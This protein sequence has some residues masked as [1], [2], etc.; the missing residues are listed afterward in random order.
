VQTP[1]DQSQRG[2]VYLYSGSEETNLLGSL[3]PVSLVKKERSKS[4]GYKYLFFNPVFS[5]YIRRKG[6]LKENDTSMTTS[7]LGREGEGGK[8]NLLIVQSS[9]TQ[10][11]ATGKS[12]RGGRWIV[13]RLRRRRG[14]E[15][16][17]R[18]LG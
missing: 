12:L 17:Y 8:S 11:P 6:K 5:K 13:L 10:Y 16:A 3:F 7:A 2:K 1:H 4:G 14:K 18:E 9:V 15:K